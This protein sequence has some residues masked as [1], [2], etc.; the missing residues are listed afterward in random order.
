MTDTTLTKLNIEKLSN[1]D[2]A[3]T[4]MFNNLKIG[5]ILGNGA[6]GEV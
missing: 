6:E 5:R 4:Q 3:N 2:I 1:Y